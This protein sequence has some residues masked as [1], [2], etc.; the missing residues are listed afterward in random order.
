MTTDF[1]IQTEYRQRER[2]LARSV[3][4]RRAAAERAAERFGGDRL[5]LIAY[6][7]RSARATRAVGSTQA[8]C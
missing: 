5:A 1:I 4:R 6:L 7:A 2:E 3:E 8:A